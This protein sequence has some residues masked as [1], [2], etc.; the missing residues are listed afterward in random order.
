MGEVG[1]GL[2]FPSLFKPLGRGQ[3]SLTSIL[4]VTLKY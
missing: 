3:I 1:I 4:S 2:P